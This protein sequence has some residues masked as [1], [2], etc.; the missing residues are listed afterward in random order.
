LV[1]SPSEAFSG[2]PTQSIFNGIG[3]CVV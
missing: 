2:G 3:H 1:F